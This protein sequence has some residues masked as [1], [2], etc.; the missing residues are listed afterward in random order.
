MN[1][2]GPAPSKK[3]AGG[4]TAEHVLEGI[5][6]N[7]PLISQDT[8]DAYAGVWHV[9]RYSAYAAGGEEP[10]PHPV[11]GW[12]A[13]TVLT[14]LEIRKPD[15]AKGERDPTFTVLYQPW[16]ATG[17][18]YNGN[19][20][21]KKPRVVKGIV[22]TVGDGGH[23]FFLGVS[24]GANGYPLCII[25]PRQPGDTSFPCL[26]LRKHERGPIFASRAMVVRAKTGA[27]LESLKEDVGVYRESHL[28]RLLR[29]KWKVRDIEEILRKVRNVV[30][31]GGKHC[32]WL[33]E[34]SEHFAA[35]RQALDA[36]KARDAALAAHSEA[37]AASA[38]SSLN[39]KVALLRHRRLKSLRPRKRA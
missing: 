36:D 17:T 23:L 39:D 26:V 18:P 7:R 35:L 24:D 3:T 37:M 6:A 27:D 13:Q 5:K 1:A 11:S 15:P 33:L 29:T 21:D 19:S 14:A 31:Y 20:K 30:P 25:A 34:E 4:S 12:N 9:I 2:A 28:I 22:L 32:L 10:E 8:S 16:S 38:Q